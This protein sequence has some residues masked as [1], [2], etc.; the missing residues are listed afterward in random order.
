M[1]EDE[2]K[3]KWC[4]MVRHPIFPQEA[5]GGNLGG[6]C[7]SS[8]C[9]MWRWIEDLS[10]RNRADDEFRRSGRRIQ[11]EEGYCGLAGKLEITP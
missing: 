1:T 6:K 10:W 5:G 4:P 3:T 8:A 9:M 11:H 7:I 2:A